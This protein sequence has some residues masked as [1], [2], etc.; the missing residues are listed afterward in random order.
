MGIQYYKVNN[1]RLELDAGGVFVSANL[2]TAIGKSYRGILDDLETPIKNMEPLVIIHGATSI[3]LVSSVR[4]WE[5]GLLWT[6]DVDWSDSPEVGWAR[7]KDDGQ[8]QLCHADP[9]AEKAEDLNPMTEEELK[10][11]GILGEDNQV[12]PWKAPRILDAWFKETALFTRKVSSS[13]GPIVEMA[14]KLTARFE[15]GKPWS[16]L[17]PEKPDE[18]I[19]QILPQALIG[20]RGDQALRWAED[21]QSMRKPMPPMFSQNSEGK[22]ILDLGRAGR[23]CNILSSPRKIFEKG[24]SPYSIYGG[25][26]MNG[27]MSLDNVLLEMAE[28][29][30]KAKIEYGEK[31]RFV[32]SESIGLEIPS[33]GFQLRISADYEN[34]NVDT[35]WNGEIRTQSVRLEDSQGLAD[36]A[37]YIRNITSNPDADLCPS[38]ERPSNTPSP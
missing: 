3:P 8:W 26:G 35:E 11:L 38:W 15:N 22:I 24:D 37:L 25:G 2:A 19:L 10:W 9:M 31:P 36:V 18:H 33:R 32:H 12:I 34:W 14:W 23:R 28:R 4:R 29:I 13:Q 17:V 16:I 27:S 6:T 5:P 30:E 21:S 7:M 1:R 20:K